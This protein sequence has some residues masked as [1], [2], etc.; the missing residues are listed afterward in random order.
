MRT[1]K[2][3]S[4]RQIETACSS[5]FSCGASSRGT[6]PTWI[7]RSSFQIATAFG[8]CSFSGSGDEREPP[9]RLE[10]VVLERLGPE[11]DAR[12]RHH[13]D[14]RIL[15]AHDLAGLRIPEPVARLG[16]LEQQAKPLAQSS[17][18]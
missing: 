11:R 16:A 2:P 5:P 1:R 12:R 18:E 10:R 4:T 6:Y 17:A 8:S 13:E 7:V 9:A 3:P 15:P 14:S